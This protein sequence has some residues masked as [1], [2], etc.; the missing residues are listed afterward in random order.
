M[1]GGTSLGQVGQIPLGEGRVFAVAGRKIAIFRTHSGEVFATQAECP[2]LRGPLADGLI[3]GT[4][5]ICP[6]HDRAYDLRTG[7]GLNGETTKLE[8]YPASLDADGNILISLP[9]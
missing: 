4:T 9:A 2:H 7:Q 6:L 1:T 5:V 3:R 8:V